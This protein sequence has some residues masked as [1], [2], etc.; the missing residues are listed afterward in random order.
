[1]PFDHFSM[2]K[3][4]AD[5]AYQSVHGRPYHHSKISAKRKRGF[6]RLDSAHQLGKDEVQTSK[7]QKPVTE[8]WA[9]PGPVSVQDW[10]ATVQ[11]KPV[12]C[13]GR[14]YR[15]DLNDRHCVKEMLTQTEAW[16]TSLEKSGLPGWYKAWGYQHG[17]LPE[18]L[19]PLLV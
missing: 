13:L 6:G 4:H 1:M 16:M 7:I 5:A 8:E 2:V 9:L 18:L 15:A 17:V 12:K 11:E 10:R 14:W 19:W 3:W